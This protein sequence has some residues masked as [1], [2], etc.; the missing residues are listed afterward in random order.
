MK[1]ISTPADA[2]EESED[3]A[4]TVAEVVDERPEHVKR[5]EEY[6]KDERWRALGNDGE[7]DGERDQERERVIEKERESERER[8]RTA[9]L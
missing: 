3:E 9:T 1:T 4:P 2:Q 6:R 5:L 8:E 7:R